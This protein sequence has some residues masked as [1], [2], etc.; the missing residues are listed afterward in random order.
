MYDSGS[1]RVLE[2][3]SAGSIPATHTKFCKCQQENVTLVMVSSNYLTSKRGR[4]QLP[5]NRKIPADWLLTGLVSQVTYRVPLELVTRV[6]GSYNDGGTT[7]KFN[8]P[9]WTNW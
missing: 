1:R 6:N 8:M 3:R 9:P 7:Y 2:A 5:G 4:V